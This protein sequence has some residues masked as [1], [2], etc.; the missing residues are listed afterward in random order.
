MKIITLLNEKGGVGKTTLATH[1][2]A[3][4][5]IIGYKVL[6]VDADPQGN[7]TVAFGQPNEPGLYNLLVRRADFSQVVRGIPHEIYEHPGE[8][9]RGR[10]GLIPSNAETRSIATQISDA[11][12]V[13]KRFRELDNIFDVVIFD[14]SPTPSLLHGSIY[15]ATHGIIYPTECEYLSMKG[16]MDSFSHREAADAQRQEFNLGQIMLMG[17][18]PMKYRSAT[19]E[20][21]ENLADLREAFGNKVWNPIPQRTIWPEATRLNRTVWNLA[22]ESKSAAEAWSIVASAKESLAYV[23]S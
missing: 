7:A 22:P 9:V 17:I 12:E 21:Q 1:I 8:P 23:Q 20:H 15:L 6:L 13:R 11:F 16:L 4:L 18:V 5:A 14:T 3:G 10:L 2:A 19:L